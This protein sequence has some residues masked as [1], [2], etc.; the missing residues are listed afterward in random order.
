MS[1]V[2]SIGIEK[3]KSFPHSLKEEKEEEDS[4]NTTVQLNN[5]LCRSQKIV[6]SCYVMHN[7]M[8]CF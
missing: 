3:L 5:M 8:N 2:A 4:S 1:S 7:P 6:Q